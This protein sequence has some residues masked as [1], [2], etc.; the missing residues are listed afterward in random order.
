MTENLFQEHFGNGD[1]LK[2]LFDEAHDLIQ[3]VH[4]D[5]TLL[6]VNRA[7]CTLLEYSPEEIKGKS[8]YSFIHE[9]DRDRYRTYRDGIIYGSPPGEIVFNLQ[10]KSGKLLIVEGRVT[11]KKKNETP[12]YTQGI[13]RDITSRLQNEAQL[14]RLNEEL[15]E[16]EHNLQQLLLHAPDAIVVIDE[17]SRITFWNTKAEEVFGWKTEEVMLK[18][19]SEIIVPQQ[20]RQAH[21]Q[22]MHRYLTTGETH[23]LNKTIEI[24]ALHKN[25]SE[26]YVSLTISRTLQNGKLSF[27]SFIRDI[28]QQKNN[29]LELEQKTQELERSNA[30]LEEFAYAASHDLKEPIRKIFTF[31]DRLKLRL[32]D[33][34]S[35]DEVQIFERMENAT[36]RMN[37][38][39]D[40]L[41]SYSHVSHGTS[42]IEQIDLNQEV[43]MVLEDLEVEIQE[44]KA[45][46]KL[47]PLPVIQGNHQQIQQLFQNLIGNALKYCKPGTPPNISIG[48][49]VVKGLE[50]PLPLSLDDQQ[51]Q[52]HFI[53]VRDN[54]IGFEQ[55][56]AERIFN[57]F[58]RLHG[59][60][61]YKGTG[62]GL[63]IVRKVVQNHKGYIWAE[64]KPN[65]GAAFKMLFPAG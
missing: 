48:A 31:S 13:F 53:E 26:F 41:L 46:I 58:T 17:T 60:A 11:V 45:E 8:L 1:W 37:T 28:T 51:K 59:N 63:S 5:G 62:V 44:K 54:G 43:L 32:K 6:Y 19:L 3:I 10:T 21:A 30:N 65:E 2:D 22:G 61:E 24:T 35:E 4:L 7:W 15:G 56:D 29:Q 49:K 34:L 25:G 47:D 36:R 55:Q 57:V 12:I 9:A 23:V 16:R 14:R 33:K 27:I 50:T 52:F 18:P 20:Y 42:A 39:I 38:L 64:G 40:D